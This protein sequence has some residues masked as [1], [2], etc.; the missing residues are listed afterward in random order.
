M[1]PCSSSTSSSFDGPCERALAGK[2]ARRITPSLKRK[3]S[4]SDYLD[5]RD[6]KTASGF[7]W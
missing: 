7:T 3:R 2:L 5:E 1:S 6:S 4:D